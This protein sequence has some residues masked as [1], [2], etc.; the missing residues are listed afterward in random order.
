MPRGELMKKLLASYGQDDEF[1]AVAEELIREE[2]KKNNTVLAKSLRKSLGNEKAKASPP[3]RLS[4]LLPFPDAATDYVERVQ[5][6]RTHRD[7]VLSS[8]NFRALA[9]VVREFRHAEALRMHG[10][11]NRSKLLFCGPPGTGKTVCAEAFA[12]ELKLPLF[13]V[14][15]D[16]LVSSYLGRD[17]VE[18]SE[19]FEFARKHPCV[20]FLDEFDAIASSRGNANDH[21]ELRRVVNSLL[22]FIDRIRPAGFLIAATNM[23]AA[24]DPAVWRRFDDVIWFDNPDDKMVRRFLAMKLRNV[25]T[26]FDATLFTPE[27][28]G[29]SYAELERICFQAMKAAV[30]QSKREVSREEFAT[31]MSDEARRRVGFQAVASAR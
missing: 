10:L 2:E 12:S 24:L 13:V 23:D 5:P 15:L 26:S 30:M 18:C 19:G 16:R 22:L 11:S 25:R 14:K 17:R 27:L 21:S 8:E 20:L 1:R 7:V 3:S 29:Y 9:G 4:P 28:V 6:S 31:A